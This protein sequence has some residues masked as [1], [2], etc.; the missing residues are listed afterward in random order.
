MKVIH[1]LTLFAAL[2]AGPASAAKDFTGRI[3]RFGTVGLGQEQYLP[4]TCAYAC[5]STMAMWML[6]CP[7]DPSAHADMHAGMMH[8]ASPECFAANDPFLTSLAWCIKTHCADKDLSVSV[9]ERFW[10]MNVAG[11]KDDQP[12]PKYSYQDAL[13][14]IKVTPTGKYNSSLVLNE[15]QLVDEFFYSMVYGSLYGIE[16][17]IGLTNQYT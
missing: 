13:A 12:L 1:A 15:T 3:A 4:A 16:I 17:N 8:H 6:E 14:R 10:E 5:R 9:L 7:D 2:G 11:R